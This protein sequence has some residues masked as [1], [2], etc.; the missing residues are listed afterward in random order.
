V[1][2]KAKIK[3]SKYPNAD[4][5]T[6]RGSTDGPASSWTRSQGRGC[7]RPAS[8]GSLD[9]SPSRP[10]GID[11]EF[12]AP[13]LDLAL[14]I[15]PSGMGCGDADQGIEAALG[16]GGV[17]CEGAILQTR[18]SLADPDGPAQEFADFRGEDAIATV[19]G[20][21]DIAQHVGE[22]DLMGI[23]QSLAPSW[24]DEFASGIS[25]GT[26]N[27]HKRAVMYI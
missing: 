8:E 14:E 7:A 24:S 12:G 2:E 25:N 13:R 11:E 16:L 21:L 17:V 5:T 19:D 27:L 23:G 1:P 26:E 9:E 3:I 15:G 20:V 4:I 6:N 22:A 18:S 10:D